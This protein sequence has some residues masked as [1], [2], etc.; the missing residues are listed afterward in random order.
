MA[1]KTKTKQQQ[2]KKNPKKQNL[3]NVQ[4]ETQTV[5]ELEYVE[6]Q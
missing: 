5:Y 2:Q 6:K 4:N 3:K 1:K